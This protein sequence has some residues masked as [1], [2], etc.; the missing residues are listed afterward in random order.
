MYDIIIVGGG[1]SGLYCCYNI[2]KYNPKL[3]VC[4][5]EKSGRWGGR[6]YTKYKD[7][8]SFESGAGRF[9][10]SHKNLMHLINKFKLTNKLNP[11]SKDVSYF[12][13]NQWIE[14][15]NQL[16]S[17]YK[18][19]FK[20]LSSIWKYIF[21]HKPNNIP[22]TLEEHCINIGL[23]KNETQCVK[24]TYGYLTE[25]IDMNSN[26]ALDMIRYDF[27]NGT[28]YTLM[29]GL[30]QLI[31]IM[32]NKCTKMGATMLLNTYCIKM[33][34]YKK[35]ITLSNNNELI[36]NKIILTIPI[37]S[38]N[39][40]E[41]YPTLRW[42]N[43][44][45]PIPYKLLRIYTKYPFG[46]FKGMN[47]IITDMS[48]SMII[49]IN[50]DKGLIMISYSDN[51]NAEY[52]NNFT[53]INKL[54]KALSKELNK[55]FPNIDIPE[56]EWISLEYWSE[57]CHYWNKYTNDN[58]IIN[59]IEKQL[60][61]DIYLI[62]E[63]YTH[64]NGWIESSL[65]IANNHINKINNTINGGSIKYTINDVQKHNSI[66][67]GVWTIIN[68][69][70]Y[71]ITKW[72]PEHPGGIAKIMQIAGKDGTDLFMNNP[73]HKGTDANKILDKYYIGDLK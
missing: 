62:N 26:N 35:S 53:D 36:A 72:V 16:M 31:D 18:S 39:A 65:I 28:F 51:I 32:V 44:N 45:K 50:P 34:K 10:S 64:I 19:S 54:K 59:N 42:N 3:K 22:S 11:L 27:E 40:I 21:S 33:N 41:I 23:S 57:G 55:L 2:L 17:L 56:P 49:P 14:N 13:K 38:L 7:G 20:S 52:W 5:I 1:I 24:D 68:N 58:K 30:Q 43:H 37:N 63:A 61:K 46:W 60:G 25:F 29:G 73:F 69:K 15:D 70:V 67:K 8:L 4:I 47:K 9:H 66:E 12:M 71:D 48:I 6:I